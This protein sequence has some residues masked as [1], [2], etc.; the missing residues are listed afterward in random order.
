ME[1]SAAASAAAALVVESMAAVK[2]AMAAAAGV[3]G[4]VAARKEM[5]PTVVAATEVEVRVA[6][7]FQWI[8]VVAPWTG[9]V[10]LLLRS[11]SHDL[12]RKPKL[13]LKVPK[14]AAVN[15]QV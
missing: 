5:R 6:T 3:A 14:Q 1:V 2:P 12:S 11:N 9:G 10:R 4:V 15:A 8:G 7:D 13:K